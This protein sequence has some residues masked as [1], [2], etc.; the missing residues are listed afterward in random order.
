MLY[1]HHFQHNIITYLLLILENGRIEI[2]DNDDK[3]HERDTF[4]DD[5]RADLLCGEGDPHFLE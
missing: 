3:D 4:P 2:D 5:R 1:H